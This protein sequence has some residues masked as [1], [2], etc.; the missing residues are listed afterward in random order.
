MPEKPRPSSVSARPVATW[1]VTSVSVRKPKSSENRAPTTIAASAPSQ[2][3]PV[4]SATP[5]PVRAPITI[6]P[7]TP[8]LSTPERST[9]SSPTAAIRSGVAAVAI[10]SR[11]ASSMP[12]GE[13]RGLWRCPH[14][15]DPVEDQRVAGEHEE[16]QHALEGTDRLVG[17]ADRRLGR[18]APEIGQRQHQPG[19]DDA[20]RVQPAEKGD[21][22][23]R[24]AV[25]RRDRRLQLVDR[26]RYF[27]D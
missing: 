5:K 19:H 16:Q 10:V 26:A 4:D 25:A 20:E 2:G 7:S 15:T 9:T 23:R 3:E 21:D 1:L 17:D 27:R 24:E 6:M 18:L 14:E 11:M 13:L 22:D 8:R 12:M